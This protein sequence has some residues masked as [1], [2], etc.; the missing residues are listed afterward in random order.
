MFFPGLRGVSQWIRPEL[1][2]RRAAKGLERAAERGRI[3]SM[4][5]HPHNFLPEPKSL[6]AAF[7]QICRHAAELREAGKL[8]ILTMSEA[9]TQLENGQGE[10]WR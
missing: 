6:L 9:A 8:Q 1:R 4:F 5:A 3:F 2:V 7:E 10:H